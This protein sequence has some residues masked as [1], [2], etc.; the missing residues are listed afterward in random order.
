MAE[1][2]DMFEIVELLPELAP[3]VRDGG[4]LGNRVLHH[5][6]VI[7]PFLS[8]HTHKMANRQYQA[9]VQAVARAREAG[10][11]GT[12]VFLHERPYRLDAFAE[13]WVSKNSFTDDEYWEVL[14]HIWIDTESLSSEQDEWFDLLMDERPGRHEHFMDEQDRERF[15]ALPDQVTVWRGWPVEG[16][17]PSGLSWTLDRE[18]AVWFATRFDQVGVVAEITVPKEEIIA[19][20]VGRGE[21]EVIVDPEFR[22]VNDRRI[23]GKVK[24]K[25]GQ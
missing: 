11:W 3:Y 8:P 5:P 10:D 22:V 12:F 24:D 20:L 2:H 1:L 6:Y 18:R 16:G 4:S 25:G 9:K 15:D 21:D 17:N 7:D 13:V 23:V 14:S 19:V